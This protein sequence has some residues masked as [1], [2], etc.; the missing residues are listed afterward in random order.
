MKKLLISLF[1]SIFLL[2]NY[3]LLATNINSAKINISSQNNS[4]TLI[5]IDIDSLIIHQITNNSD[6]YS[7]IKF[8]NLSTHAIIGKPNLPVFTLKFNATAN[9]ISSSLNILE[10]EIIDLNN[11]IQSFHDIAKG[12]NFP[13]TNFKNS[14]D[15]YPLSIINTHFNGYSAGTPI[16]SLYYFP[17]QIISKNKIRLIKR[18]E[19]TITISQKDLVFNN[20]Q[21]LNQLFSSDKTGQ[22]TKSLK[23]VSTANSQFEKPFIKLE[24]SK[25]GIY[26][27]DYKTLKNLDINIKSINPQSFTLYNYGKQVPIYIYGEKDKVFHNQ[28]YIEFIGKINPNSTNNSSKFDPFTNTNVYQLFWNIENGLR[29]TE[30]SANPTYKG[31]DL[32]IPVEFDYLYHFEN[33]ESFQTLGQ[34]YQD[35]LSTENDQYFFS[36]KI[37]SGSSVDFEFELASPN[38]NTTKNIFMK[39]KLQSIS[40]NVKHT[41]HVLINGQNIGKNSWNWDEEGL[42]EQNPEFYLPNNFLKN[43]INTL[44]INLEHNFN[45][46]TSAIMM[47]WL[48]IQY[49]RDFEAVDNYIEFNKPRDQING[50]Y[51]FNVKNFTN[52]EISVY[53]NNSTK[54]T[55]FQKSY[56]SFSETYSIRLQDQINSGTS[57]IAASGES[58][59]LPDSC[60]LDTM[61]NILDIDGCDH[62][63]IV[64]DD[65]YAKSKELED[66]YT[67]QGIN[68]YRVKLSDIYNQFNYGI[69]SPYAIKN[70][71]KSAYDSWQKFPKW[72]LLI[73][74]ANLTDNSKNLLPTMMYQTY[75]YGGSAS[76]YWYSLL[77]EDDNLPDIAIG[78]WACGT[79]PEFE[80]LLNKRIN[81]DNQQESGSWRNKYLFIAGYEDLFKIQTDYLT[82]NIMI[83]PVSLSR[84]LI[85]PSNQSS[86][87]FAGTDTLIN[88]I[89]RGL[90]V[91]NFMGHGGGAVWAD[92]SLLRLEDLYKL[93]NGNKLPFLSSLTCFTSDFAAQQSLGEAIT[94]QFQGGAIGLFGSSGVGW[95]KNDFLLGQPLFKY[96]QNDELSIG[97]IIQLT[98][99]DYLTKNSS[100]GYL[101]NSMVFQYNLLGDPGIVL[102]KP[103]EIKDYLS[104]QNSTVQ[105]NEQ[106]NISGEL[107]FD[108]GKVEIQ[109]YDNKKYPISPIIPYSFTNNNFSASIF[110]PDSTIESGYLN[111]YGTNSDNSHD[112]TS[113]IYFASQKTE[114]K[115]FI[116]SPENINY[117]DNVNISI[118]FITNVDSVFWEI[119]TTSVSQ[120]LNQ[121]GITI[122]SAF[123]PGDNSINSI[124]CH[125]KLDKIYESINSFKPVNPGKYYAHRI[126]WFIGGEKF[127]GSSMIF[128][129]NKTYDINILSL[130]SGGIT[131]PSLEVITALNGQDTIIST[132][133]VYSSNSYNYKESSIIFTKTQ[134][135]F[136]MSENKIY[137]PI[138]SGHKSV[139]GTVEIIGTGIEQNIYN[140]TK[141]FNFPINH[142]QITPELGTSFSG[143]SNDTIWMDNEFFINIPSNMVNDSCVLS[144]KKIELKKSSQ[145]DFRF[146]FPSD[147]SHSQYNLKLSKKLLYNKE[148]TIGFISNSNNKNLHITYYDP[149]L[150]L[151]K[152]NPSTISTIIIS[153]QLSK[154]GEFTIAEINDTKIPE[155]EINFDGKRINDQ[156]FVGAYPTISFIFNDENGINL[157]DE[158][159][160]FWIDDEPISFDLLNKGD[161]LQNTNNVNCSY[162]SDLESGT[163]YL[164]IKIEDAAKNKNEN[165]YEFTIFK[166]LKIMD[167]GNYPNPF[168]TRTWFVFETTKDVEEF[169][170]NIYSSSGRKIRTIDDTNIFENKEMIES[171]YHEVSWDGKDDFGD[172][173]SNGVYYYKMIAK[174]N[175]KTVSCKGVIAKV[176]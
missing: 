14:Y 21:Q 43:G 28:D 166:N 171:G 131:Q 53:K 41:A 7:S 46:Q 39:L 121:F 89:N 84:I 93:R 13:L 88:R 105:P 34:I 134:K 18:A 104:I 60:Y 68:S 31:R 35:I 87:F 173:I 103:D 146:I 98:K 149:L 130:K 65:F 152:S 116:L 99:I 114:Y 97:E 119:D 142:F 127:S 138:L 122:I 74:D 137:L 20:N 56:D 120:Y 55:K 108:N 156:N 118:D 71:L 90:K 101:K 36:K 26:K 54:I 23:K 49:Y 40:Q 57:Y 2:P 143:I 123:Q 94:E 157:S 139:L 6:L 160:K 5:T 107:P 63:S 106:I 163:H 133:N 37:I 151:W 153:S 52:N 9:N 73:G 95:M 100:F 111:I 85:N 67:E 3:I 48:E 1:I 33:N 161:T 17:I 167:Y 175:N 148:A 80:T 32:I 145:P 150:N 19:I 76:D 170:I 126:S 109:I 158:G 112:F 92:N 117:G 110:L 44:T 124:K 4:K 136:P 38:Q 22:I 82:E 61:H 141:N 128:D 27:I 168:Q 113:A 58:L 77:N 144:I 91:V 12:K 165:E 96:L 72:A 132:I 78:R 129:I 45:D 29:F 64:A 10:E 62:L 174:T 75:K 102:A 164:K 159:F 51:Q 25:D 147:T 86:R 30:E 162:R 66:F 79:M 154:F 81:Y 135:L 70:F 172:D 140:N 176:K 115:N 47:D 155:I 11:P 24:V 69:V 59:S 8:S 15:Q 125:K 16:S 50:Y 42:I 83:P 169:K